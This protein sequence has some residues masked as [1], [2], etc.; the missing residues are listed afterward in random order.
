MELSSDW[1]DYKHVFTPSTPCTE[2]HK[3]A[4]AISY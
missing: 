4:K 2:D 1:K 3:V